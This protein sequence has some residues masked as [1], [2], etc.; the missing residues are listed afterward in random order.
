MGGLHALDQE[1]LAW[2]KPLFPYQQLGVDRLVGSTSLLLGACLFN[3]GGNGLA[4][5]WRCLGKGRDPFWSRP[6]DYPAA[7]GSAADRVRP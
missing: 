5:N 7:C 1:R 6:L 4:R 2:A 3:R